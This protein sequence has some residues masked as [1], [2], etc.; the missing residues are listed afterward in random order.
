MTKPEHF[1][2][3]IVRDASQPVIVTANAYRMPLDTPADYARATLA[4]AASAAAPGGAPPGRDGPRQGRDDARRVLL[5]HI[6]YYA[7]LAELTQR[8]RA[9]VHPDTRLF[10]EVCAPHFAALPAALLAPH[11]LLGVDL[12]DE[13]LRD[14]ADGAPVVWFADRIARDLDFAGGNT[15][16]CALWPARMAGA[17]DALL[18]R[19]WPAYGVRIEADPAASAVSRRCSHS[20]QSGAAAR[21]GRR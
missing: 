20:A 17:L 3:R 5:D 19:A 16:R 1:S 14:A 21:P 8:V 7:F 6:Q 18:R 15:L 11:V 9:A 13:A 4:A 12:Y 10:F 2:Y